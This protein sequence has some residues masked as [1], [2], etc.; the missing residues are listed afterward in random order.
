MFKT[1]DADFAEE[2]GVTDYP[3]LVFFKDEIPNV[4]EGNI[5]A[6]EEVLDWLIEMKVENHIEL[7]T[8]PMLEVMVDEIQYLAVFFFKQN[9]RTCDQ[10]LLELENIDDECDAYGVQMVKLQDPQLA[11][12]YGIKTFPALVY[13]R[14]GNPLTFDGDLKNEESVLEWIIDDDNRELD[15]EIEAVNHKMLDKLMDKSQLLAVFFYDEDCNECESILEALEEIDDEADEYGI[16]FVKNDDPRTAKQ[17]DIYNTPTLVY[18]RKSLP[19]IYDGDL[20]DG[21]KVLEW[22]TSQDVFEI[23][24]EI[25]Q[26]NRKLLDKLLEENDF[27]A[28]YF[29]QDDCK[30]CDKV[31]EGLETVDEETAAL[32]ITFVKMNDPR[33]AKKYGVNKLPALVYFRRKF[34][35]IYRDDLYEEK[36]VMEWLKK[37]RFKHVELDLFMYTIIAIAVTFMLYTAFLMFGFKPAEPEK[38][39]EE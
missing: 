17:Y 11:K 36:E 12:R 24:D 2:I 35:S 37:N 15:D 14:N 9:C 23:K 28:V 4:Y 6:E 13:F 21:S 16:D 1:T 10:V 5:E 18:Y 8:R 29:Y 19:I 3:A 34:P 38:K 31:L 27:V 33:Y 20:T 7:I 22:L 25:E 30:E 39:K 26:V 32:D